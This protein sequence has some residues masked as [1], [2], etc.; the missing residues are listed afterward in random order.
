[1]HIYTYF[2]QKFIFVKVGPAG[3][4]KANTNNLKTGS[5][6][7]LSTKLQVKEGDLIIVVCGEGYTPVSLCTDHSFEGFGVPL[8]DL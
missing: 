3:E 8:F 1:M 6:T 7:A 5:V 4:F 2:L